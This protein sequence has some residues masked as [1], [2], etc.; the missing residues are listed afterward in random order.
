MQLLDT[1]GLPV[2]LSDFLG[3]PVVLNFWATWCE[4]CLR[5]MP[6]LDRLAY[7]AESLGI[8]VLAVSIDEDGM[9]S[10]AR[11]LR[12]KAIANLMVLLDP[13]L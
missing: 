13:N 10:V 2:R 9:T 12:A 7:Q 1:N 5:E 4:P 3:R 11:F 6:S 8:V